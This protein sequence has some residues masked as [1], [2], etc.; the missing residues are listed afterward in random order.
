MKIA[1]LAGVVLAASLYQGAWATSAEPEI[2]TDALDAQQ[3]AEEMPYLDALMDGED[4]LSQDADAEADLMSRRGRDRDG[5]RWRRP[6]PR[7]RPL[8]TR[9][10]CFARN[11][12]TR[13][14]YRAVGWGRNPRGV[15]NAAIRACRRSTP[16]DRL[17]RPMGC[18][19][20]R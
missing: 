20:F 18:R 6:P 5:R 10:A 14:V 4:L 13:V 11:I 9:V 1:K 7:R 8:P 12:R 15:Q 2:Y 16:F 19:R 17:C 3:L